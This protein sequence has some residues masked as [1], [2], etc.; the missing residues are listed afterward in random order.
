M[1]V[2]VTMNMQARP[3]LAVHSLVSSLPV[4]VGVSEL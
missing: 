2:Y 1:L 3:T 4:L